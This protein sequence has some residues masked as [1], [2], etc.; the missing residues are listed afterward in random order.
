MIFASHPNILTIR[1]RRKGHSEDNSSYTRSSEPCQ[2]AAT[3]AGGG[4][5]GCWGRSCC[6]QERKEKE[7]QHLASPTAAA[8]TRI[9]TDVELDF[10][11]DFLISLLFLFSRLHMNKKQIWDIFGRDWCAN[12]PLVVA[13]ISLQSEAKRGHT[14]NTCA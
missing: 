8:A 9:H 3:R 4:G 5:G 6:C 10:G 2:G 1:L 14:G 13:Q 11:T 12:V 7:E